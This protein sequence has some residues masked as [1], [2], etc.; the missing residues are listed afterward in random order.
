MHAPGH[1]LFVLAKRGVQVVAH[2]VATRLDALALVAD[3]IRRRSRPLRASRRDADTQTLLDDGL[4]VELALRAHIGRDEELVVHA[5]A[6]RREVDCVCCGRDV[7][8][9]D[10]RARRRSPRLLGKQLAE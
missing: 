3:I 4:P 5:R 8:V 9:E 1:T 7:V 6:E 2:H 10:E